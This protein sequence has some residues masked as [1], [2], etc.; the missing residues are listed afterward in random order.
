[1]NRIILLFALVAFVSLAGCAS[2]GGSGSLPP[3]VLQKGSLAN[4]QLIQD[5]MRGVVGK[6]ATL[7]C[8]S[9][10]SY[11]PYVL[12]MPQGTPG[13][14]VWRERWVVSC[15]GKTYPINIRFSE[16]GMGSADY[17]IQ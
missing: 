3:G 8:A 13:A 4:Q 12:A 2:T 7:G 1:M 15:S 17:V 5:A 11:E 14:R 9:I 6:A 10:D 16:S